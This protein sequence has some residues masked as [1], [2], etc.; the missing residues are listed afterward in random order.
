MGQ[1]IMRN[2]I[3]NDSAEVINDPRWI[4][5]QS[6]DPAADGEFVYAVRS[7]GIYCRPTCPS[8]LAKPE[9]IAFYANPAS[10]EQAGFRPCLR[11]KPQQCSMAEEQAAMVTRLCRFIEAAATLPTLNELARHAGMST[12]HLHRIFKAVTGLTPFSYAR[13][14]RAGRVRRELEDGGSVTQAIY[15]AGFNASGSFYEESAHLLGMTPSRYRAG[16]A[17]ADIRFA[18]A[19]CSLGCVLV[20][21]SEK[22][23]CAILLGDDPEVLV[24]DLKQRFHAANLLGG[25]SDFEET[26]VRVISYVNAKNPLMDLPLDIRGTAFQRRVWEVLRTIPAGQTL[27]YSE[28]AGRIGAPQACRAVAQACAANAL[29]VV[30]PCHRVVRSDGGLSGYRWGVERKRALLERE[31]GSGWSE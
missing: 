14:H 1:S 9:N 11:C 18:V 19:E 12:Y 26:V 20:A 17:G 16:G 7:T 25:D 28:V 24:N 13:A 8:R 2:V 6:R 4:I 27:S 5:L 21:Q 23:I 10:A 3:R 22:G 29:A 15:D 30:I 31:A